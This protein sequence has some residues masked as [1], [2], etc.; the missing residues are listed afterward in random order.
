[1]FNKA[2][3]YMVLVLLPSICLAQKY[4]I[5]AV[6]DTGFVRVLSNGMTS[7][8]TGAQLSAQFG[9]GPS[10]ITPAQITVTQNNYDPSGFATATVVRISSNTTEIWGIT[11]FSATGISSGAEKKIM[12]VGSTP[13]YLAGEHPSSTAANRLSVQQDIVLGAKQ[14][15]T[16]IYDGTASRWIVEGVSMNPHVFHNWA[17]ASATIGDW[18]IVSFNAI[19]AGTVATVVAA[20]NTTPVSHRISTATT[21]N[22][23][24]SICITKSVASMNRINTGHFFAECYISTPSALSDG[25]NGYT[26]GLS[27][28]NATTS[29]FT[30]ANSMG[31]KYTH[32]LNSGK[33]TLYAINSGG[34]ATEVDLGVTVAALT[35]YRLR[36]EGNDAGTELR[37]Y[38][39]G[40]MKGVVSTNLPSTTANLMPRIVLLKSAGTSTTLLE[41]FSLQ[42]GLYAKI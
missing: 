34:T 30:E 20:T 6:S 12:N 36:L 38:V 25:T 32:T 15:V 39:N 4:S 2:V 24:G 19:N 23:G 22:G 11:G 29:T 3:F 42:T 8:L 7:T 18:G 9:S 26:A 37:A 13:I 35:T 5:N 10:V 14:S 17:A 33:W 16:I 40:E 27:Y 41:C 1:M 31:I 21:T 28:A